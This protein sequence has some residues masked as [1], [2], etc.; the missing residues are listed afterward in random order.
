MDNCCFVKEDDSNCQAY[1]TADSAY[2]FQHNPANAEIRL[3]ASKKGGEGRRPLPEPYGQD[4]VLESPLD[5]R[6]FL[7]SVINAVWTGKAPAQ[8]GSSMGFLARCWLDAHE[9]SELQ[10]KISG[11]EKRL[12]EIKL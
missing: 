1:P 2:C 10:D 9:A 8:A 6:T 7:G 11:L 12:D 5:V 3:L 4:V